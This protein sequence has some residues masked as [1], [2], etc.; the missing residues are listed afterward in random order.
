LVE[1]VIHFCY[2]PRI[3]P[4]KERNTMKCTLFIL[5]LAIAGLAQAQLKVGGAGK[6]RKPESLQTVEVG[7][8]PGHM[9]LVM[10]YSCTWMTPVEMAGVKA[11]SYTAAIS[12][13][14][15]GQRSQDRGYV[16]V[17]MENG[18][19]AFVRV[20]GTGMATEKGPHSGEGTWAYTGGTGT[21]KGLKG[22]GTYKSSGA[23]AD[24]TDDQIEGEYTLP[25]K[26]KK[27]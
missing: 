24:S 4:R 26:A 3:D 9:L 27:D 16:V 23:T 21:L 5:P 6:C 20:Q 18:D 8:R 11:K 2:L 17:T 1:D 22:K 19:K 14:A 12:S 10:K 25:E 15:M 13:D 7:D